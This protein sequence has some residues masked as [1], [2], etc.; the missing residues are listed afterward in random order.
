MRASSMNGQDERYLN[1]SCRVSSRVIIQW[2]PP[3]NVWSLRYK[4][5]RLKALLAADV[6]KI[7]LMCFFFFSG[8]EPVSFESTDH[9]KCFSVSMGAR[10][11]VRIQIGPGTKLLF[12]SSIEKCNKQKLFHNHSTHSFENGLDNDQRN[13]S[14]ITKKISM[15]CDLSEF[16]ATVQLI[17]PSPRSCFLDMIVLCFMDDMW[18]KLVQMRNADTDC[19]IWI[20]INTQKCFEHYLLFYREYSIIR[21]SVT[22]HQ[23]MHSRYFIVVRW[24]IWMLASYQTWREKGWLLQVVR[25][26][27]R[28]K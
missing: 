26:T 23:N 13:P 15:G 11:N 16:L 14:C 5:Q 22:K 19:P 27:Q 7:K 3:N 17:Y 20:W 12:F 18:L 2:K 8:K 24:K 9:E 10:E 28:T 1:P 4:S 25:K 21:L 6:H